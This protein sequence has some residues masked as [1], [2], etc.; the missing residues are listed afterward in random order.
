MEFDAFDNGRIEEYAAR[1]RASWGATPEYR[2]YEERS[3]DRSAADNADLGRRMMKIFTEFG[4]VR[5]GDPASPAAQALVR[6]LQAFISE[7]F[8]TCSDAVLL[9]LGKMYAA[10]GD[11][12]ENID[13]HGG[14]GTADFVSRAIEAC[15]GRPSGR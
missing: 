10:G 6:K 11:Y 14:Q 12:T 7:H 2:E 1:A 9:G 3:R 13:R 15:C 4:A 8:Y 5:T